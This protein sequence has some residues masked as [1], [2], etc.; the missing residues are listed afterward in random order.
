M[1]FI[2]KEVILSP[3]PG[4]TRRLSTKTYA[5][6]ARSMRSASL[7]KC[8]RSQNSRV[9]DAQTKHHQRTQPRHLH[10]SYLSVRKLD[11]VVLPLERSNFIKA[12]WLEQIIVYTYKFFFKKNLSLIQ[13]CAI[14]G[15][16]ALQGTR[17]KGESLP[18]D[19]ITRSPKFFSLPPVL[20][21]YSIT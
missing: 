2:S 21:E 6:L 20:L 13:V 15:H 14:L 1:E 4:I 16:H 8:I 17:T 19:V 18:V 10:D 11:K 3:G 5:T 12:I 7:G 9:V